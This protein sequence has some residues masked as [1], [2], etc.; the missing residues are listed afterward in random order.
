MK[1]V[2]AAVLVLAL[3]TLSTVGS[4]SNAAGIVSRGNAT[5]QLKDVNYSSDGSSEAVVI[6]AR[7]YVDYSVI[8]LSEPRR[9]VLDIYNV[10]APG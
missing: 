9:I 7:D 5:G 2:A 3:I 10:T 6:T 1:K 8:E 4:F